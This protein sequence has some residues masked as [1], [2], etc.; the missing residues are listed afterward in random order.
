LHLPSAVS[1]K[2]IAEFKLKN[3]GK[4][5]IVVTHQERLMKIADRIMVLNSGKV[6]KIGESKQI[7]KEIG[8]EDE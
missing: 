6:G 3:Q 1:E 5:I 8:D 7:L 2:I 4:T